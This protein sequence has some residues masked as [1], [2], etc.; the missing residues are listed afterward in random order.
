MMR[1][2]MVLRVSSLSSVT[3]DLSESNEDLEEFPTGEKLL[4]GMSAEDRD[5]EGGYESRS[6]AVVDT[7]LLHSPFASRTRHGPLSQR[8]ASDRLA[9][10]C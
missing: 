3:V 6:I 5:N 8:F 10:N 2:A 9:I 1:C 4:D 7:L